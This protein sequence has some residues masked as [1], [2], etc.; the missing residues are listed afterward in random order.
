[1]QFPFTIRTHIPYMYMHTSYT[2]ACLY[3]HVCIRL[4]AATRAWGMCL[5]MR[6]GAVA[7]AG[8]EASKC[9][10][11]RR[12]NGIAVVV[13][14]GQSRTWRPVQAGKGA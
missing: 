8:G 10:R 11:R 12:W 1:M 5:Q 4:D 13:G 6:T 9:T 2:H 3:S 14:G 7:N